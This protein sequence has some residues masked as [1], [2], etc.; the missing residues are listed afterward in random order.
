MPKPNADT[1][2]PVI[3][4]NYAKLLGEYLAAGDSK[5][6]LKLAA[7]FKTLGE[8]KTRI[9]RGWEAIQRPDFQRQLGRDPEKLIADGV[10]AIRE[11]YNVRPS[12]S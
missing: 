4:E 2:K 11:R 8:H 9:A 12:T 5:A 1:A 7:S 10:A 6:A 3:S